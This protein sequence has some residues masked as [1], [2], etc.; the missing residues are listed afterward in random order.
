MRRPHNLAI[1]ETPHSAAITCGSRTA[2]IDSDIPEIGIN[3][4]ALDDTTGEDLVPIHASFHDNAVRWLPSVA[5]TE[6]SAT[7]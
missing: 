4:T 7:G 3:V 1:F 2:A 6:P 5:Q